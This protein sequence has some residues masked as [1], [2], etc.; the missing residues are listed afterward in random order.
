MPEEIFILIIV[1]LAAA[2]VVSVA[3]IFGWVHTT[4]MKIRNGYPLQS[5]W[6]QPLRP[7]N[8]A[9]ADERVRLVTQENAQLRAELGSMK[10][11]LATVERIVTDSGYQ[12]TH[13]INRLSDKEHM[14]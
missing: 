1:A 12:L 14:Q 4:K 7:T 10:D 2:V 9:D 3:G 11:R 5:M 8:T 13:E 6:G